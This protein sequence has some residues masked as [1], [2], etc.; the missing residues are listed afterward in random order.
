MR[1]LIL[2][3]AVLGALA[4]IGTMARADDVQPGI[5]QVNWDGHEHW[6]HWRESRHE[7]WAANRNWEHRHWESAH[8]YAPHHYSRF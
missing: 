4:T 8:R 3:R 6:E 5:H 1:T 7:G 2:T